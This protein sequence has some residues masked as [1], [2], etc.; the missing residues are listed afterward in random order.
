VVLLNLAFSEKLFSQKYGN[1]LGAGSRRQETPEEI[2]AAE[3]RKRQKIQ[4]LLNGHYLRR[5]DGQI[6]N[7]F[8]KGNLTSLLVE[9]KIDGVVIGEVSGRNRV[10]ITNFSGET[11]ANK[12]IDIVAIESGTYDCM[13]TPL[14]LYDC[15]QI[16][17][18]EEEKK[19]IARLKEQYSIVQQQVELD[20]Q[21]KKKLAE[22]REATAIAKAIQF[23]QNQ[24]DRG[25]V[26]GLLRMGQ[27]YRTGDGVE[28][29]LDKAKFYLQKAAD[30]GSETAKNEL[31]DLLAT[32]K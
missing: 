17:T 27:R 28:K 25:D 4:V 7:M 6:V 10:A 2:A 19:E 32:G 16:L 21:A 24:A 22:D 23:N 11:I 9:S 5:V 8:L 3:A 30:A 29:D 13:G 14:E 1:F 12:Y 20:R 15:G 26:F 31:D 18:P